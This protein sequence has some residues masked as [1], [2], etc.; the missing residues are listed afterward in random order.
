[1]NEGTY[2]YQNEWAAEENK[3]T[4][5][6]LSFIQDGIPPYFIPHLVLRVW[7]GCGNRVFF[8]TR[9]CEWNSH[10]S[11]GTIHFAQF[12][13]SRYLKTFRIPIGVLEIVVLLHHLHH[14]RTY[15]NHSIVHQRSAVNVH[16]I[17]TVLFR[18]KWKISELE[19]FFQ[20]SLFLLESSCT[21]IF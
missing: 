9:T 18:A 6:E 16:N 20:L 17:S 3:T 5:V 19:P 11:K 10:R 13:I 21:F 2:C 15:N 4:V 7:K 12:P 8:C 14:C 1:M